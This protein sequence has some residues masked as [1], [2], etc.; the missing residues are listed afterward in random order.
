MPAGKNLL[1]ARDGK[2]RPEPMRIRYKVALVGIIPITVA[3]AIALIAWLLLD[4]A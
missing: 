1:H 3:A 4:Q 2:P